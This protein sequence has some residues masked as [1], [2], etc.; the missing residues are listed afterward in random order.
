MKIVGLGWFETIHI[1]LQVEREIEAE[2]RKLNQMGKFA[3]KAKHVT[4]VM[5]ETEDRL[6]AQLDVVLDKLQKD[7]PAQAAVAFD[8]A[9]AVVSE[10]QRG[11]EDFSVGL[12]HLSNSAGNSEASS[13]G[14]ANTASDPQP[15]QSK[16]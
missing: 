10:L 11:V 8:K 16:S 6:V 12:Q 1:L 3:D 9:G 5:K 13:E 4:D 7:I 15:P 14:S 2:C